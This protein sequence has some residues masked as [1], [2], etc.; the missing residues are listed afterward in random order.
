MQGFFTNQ[1]CP[2]LGQLPLRQMSKMLEQ[3]LG[4]HNGQHTVPQKLQPLIAAA[5][6]LLFI[7]VGR[8]GQRL[9]QQL[10]IVEGVADD[11][12]K[13]FQTQGISCLM[14]FH[15]SSPP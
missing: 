6:L 2:D 8:M 11:L 10:L 14:L 5:Q 4:Y 1:A 13:F 3:V 12:F 9:L 7:G 15:F